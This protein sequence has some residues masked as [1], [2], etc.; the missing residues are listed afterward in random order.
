MY[1]P[2]ASREAYVADLMG[3]AL[4]G[5]ADHTFALMH[6]VSAMTPA[7]TAALRRALRTLDEG[8]DT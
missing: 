5:S 2:V 8:S 4:G 3:E 7:D 6:F 1:E